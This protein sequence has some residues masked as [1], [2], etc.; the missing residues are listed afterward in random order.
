MWSAVAEGDALLRNATIL[1]GGVLLGA[2]AAVALTQ[3]AFL[4][5]TVAN[6]AARAGYNPLLLFGEVFEAIRADYVEPPE[7]TK[8]VE[9]AVDAMLVSL[10]PHS[11]YMS[12]KSWRDMQVQTRG[13]FGGLGI[14]VTMEE[15]LVKVNNPNEDG[16][17]F[18][19]GIKPGDM[20]TDVDGTAVLGLTLNQAVEKMRGVV[21]TPVNIKVKRAGA[22]T[23]LEFKIVRAIIPI[24]S[25]RSRVEDDIGYIKVDQFTEKTYDGLQKEI[26]KIKAAIPPDRFKGYVV[27]LR[28][29][30]GG[31]VDQAVKV[32]DSFLDRGEIVSIRGRK[33]N[34]VQRYDAQA[35]DLTEGKS[36]IVLMNGASASASEI[37]AGALQDH[38]RATVLG[39]RSFGKGSVQT[40]VSLGQNGGLRLT[41]A[42][43]F[44]PAGRSIQALG[45]DPDIEVWVDVP[46][47]I[48][49]IA[50]SRGE[51][52]L[53]GHLANANGAAERAASSVYVPR[54]TTKDNQLII[55]YDLLR[56]VR[57][58]P[59]MIAGPSVANP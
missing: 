59:A 36:V 24:V 53:K 46:P 17:A 22:D 13:E 27:D 52:G 26:A 4:G 33:G 40:I 10:D 6:A 11:N 55:A 30:P 15:G 20:I 42:K 44:T 2:A 31:L 43:Y 14:E 19:A 37:V 34:D 28:N 18:K 3:P 8:L 7:D 57:T 41:T 49:A 25:V 50:Q 23:P 12:P 51:A 5:G 29:N 39:T 58:N 54:D 35:G 32:V 47:E 9:A 21:G 45:I 16:P 38:R 48:A 1:A 56:G